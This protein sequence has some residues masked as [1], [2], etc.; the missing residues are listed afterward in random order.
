MMGRGAKEDWSMIDKAM[1][2]KASLP[3]PGLKQTWDSID[4]AMDARDTANLKSKLRVLPGGQ[5]G[6]GFEDLYESSPGGGQIKQRILRLVSP[7]P[8]GGP[9][10]SPLFEQLLS[11][12]EPK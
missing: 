10:I 12:V 9:Q 3:K 11:K 2:T 7:T 1:E 6:Q 8:K 5:A 4:A